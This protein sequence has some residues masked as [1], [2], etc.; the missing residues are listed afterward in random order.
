MTPPADHMVNYRKGGGVV[1]IADGLA[2]PIEGIGNISMSLW[3]GKDWVQIVLPNATH[4]P[5][6]GYNLLSLKRMA[7]RG[8]KYIDEKKIVTLHLKNIKTLFCP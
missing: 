7:A 4:V 8:H 3:S 6:L 5:L 2:V 1:R